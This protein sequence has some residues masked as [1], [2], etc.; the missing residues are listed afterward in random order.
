M[1]GY[2]VPIKKN[3]FAKLKDKKSP[4][5]TRG[6]NEWEIP[7]HKQ[8]QGCSYGNEHPDVKACSSPG[9]IIPVHISKVILTRIF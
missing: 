8:Y 1:N 9:K 2:N 7:F 3:L 5:T 6:V 4:L